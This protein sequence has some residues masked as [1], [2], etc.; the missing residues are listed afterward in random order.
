MALKQAT[1]YEYLSCRPYVSIPTTGVELYRP[2]FYD[3]DNTG[4]MLKVNVKCDNFARQVSIKSSQNLYKYKYLTFD[5]DAFFEIDDCIKNGD[6]YTLF[7]TYLTNFGQN[8]NFY[9]SGVT[10]DSLYDSGL[11][12]DALSSFIKSAIKRPIVN[13]TFAWAVRIEFSE[14]PQNLKVGYQVNFAGT[15]TSERTGDFPCAKRIGNNIDTLPTV[16]GVDA[17][18]T[19]TSTYTVIVPIPVYGEGHNALKLHQGG[20]TINQPLTWN[21]FASALKSLINDLTLRVEVIP[22]GRGTVSNIYKEAQTDTLLSYQSFAPKITNTDY[23]IETEF[24][25]DIAKPYGNTSVCGGALRLI[26]DTSGGAT[27]VTQPY[28][29]FCCYFSED[30]GGAGIWESNQIFSVSRNAQ[31]K[32]ELSIKIAVFGQEI[33]MI[34]AHDENVQIQHI[35]NV[36]RF[37]QNYNLLKYIDIPCTLNYSKDAYSNYGAYV[38]ANVTNDFK[39]REQSLQL[40]QR[41]NRTQL[42]FSTAIKGANAVGQVLTGNPFGITAGINAVTDV[43]TSFAGTGIAEQNQRANLK[44]ERDIAYNE[45]SQTIIPGTLLQGDISLNFLKF[46]QNQIN[47]MYEYYIQLHNEY[48]KN[49]YNYMISNKIVQPSL[50]AIRNHA[51]QWIRGNDK[52]IYKF[53]A[54]PG[55]TAKTVYLYGELIFS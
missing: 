8:E 21:G 48:Y 39:N 54:E 51:P 36:I 11:T 6:V 46:S 30:G 50:V 4:H 2:R 31:I 18:C 5:N 14:I 28:P 1:L 40:Q 25:R 7:I 41:Q 27:G 15:T 53:S 22:F 17:F 29:V 3:S 10:A 42:I 55:S 52:Y 37:F 43:V 24:D 38:H 44:L 19:P 20:G 35:P 33:S 49:I 13:K 9:L 45:A 32:E 26:S 23:F 12:I 16:K 47:F 34:D